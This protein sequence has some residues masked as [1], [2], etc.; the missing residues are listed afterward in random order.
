MGFTFSLS[1]DLLRVLQHSLIAVALVV[2]NQ[3]V[4]A[5]QESPD[6]PAAEKIIAAIPGNFPPQYSIDAEGNPAGFA[7]DVMN[8]VARLADLEVQYQVHSRWVEVTNALRLGKADIVPNLG[9]TEDRQLYAD[10][11][12]PLETFSVSLFLRKDTIGIN[13]LLDLSGKLIGVVENNVAVRYFTTSGQLIV[14]YRDAPTMLF[15]LLS[16]NIDAI[17]YP[18]PVLLRMAQKIGVDD[19]IRVLSPPIMEMKRAIGVAKGRPELVT[20]LQAAVSK[21]VGSPEYEAIYTRWY[22][23]PKPF[24]TVVKVAWTAGILVVFILLVNFSWRYFVLQRLNTSLER[25]TIRRGE[26]EDKLIQ[27]NADLETKVADRT[28]ELEKRN[29]ILDT[30]DHISARFIEE[31]D[32]FVLYPELLDRLLTLTGSKYGFIGDVLTDESGELYLKNYALSNLA[33]DEETSAL[34]ETYV[35]KG[36]EFHNLDNLF[37][38]VITS[39]KPVISNDP[40][41]DNRAGGFP[42]RHPALDSF[43]GIPVFSGEQLVGEIGLANR[44]GGYDEKLIESLEQVT[45]TLGQIIVGRWNREARHQAELEL[46]VLAAT[47]HLTGIANR[48]QFR[49]RLDEEFNRADRYHESLS[50][51]MLDLDH[52]KQVNDEY[53][54]DVGDQVLVEL[55]EQIKSQIREIDLFARWGGEEFLIML[56]ETDRDTART[57]VE[58]IRHHV[59]SHEFGQPPHITISLGLVTLRSSDDPDTFI[60]RADKA[61]YKAKAA[62]RNCVVVGV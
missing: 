15:E 43:L 61:L 39:R 42:D 53:G 32:P 12:T 18:E 48:R 28:V 62:G 14:I 58:R 19:Q 26:A 34:Y 60:S 2:S 30:I 44:E 3:Q 56:P 10:F 25:E 46:T 22:A 24:W 54:H 52:F 33:W 23:H 38:S 59:E 41:N 45:T 37:G 7:I 27:L 17:A 8:E 6:T 16:G 11:T 55:T 13:S 4:L 50:L 51:V 49:E 57:M 1:R 20:R 47:D 36:F 29:A 40:A 5:Q 35:K 21:F 9:I 31:S